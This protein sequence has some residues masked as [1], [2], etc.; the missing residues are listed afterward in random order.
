MLENGLT[1]SELIRHKQELYE[2]NGQHLSVDGAVEE[3]VADACEMML[4]DNKEFVRLQQAEAKAAASFKGFMRDFVRKLKKAFTGVEATHAEAK[5]I[6]KDMAFFRKLQETW[7][8][9]VFGEG[10]ANEN[11]ATEGSGKFSFADEWENNTRYDYGVD[12]QEINAYVKS[13][14]A[15]SDEQA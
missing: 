9:G 5:A 6:E 14:Y 1:L 15:N 4:R 10:N 3:I 8:E 2:R 11:A 13:A 12:Q 7:S